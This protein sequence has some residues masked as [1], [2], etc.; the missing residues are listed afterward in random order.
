VLRSRGLPQHVDVVQKTCQAFS[1]TSLASLTV[2]VTAV[3]AVGN[4]LLA[5]AAVKTSEASMTFSDDAGGTWTTLVSNVGAVAASQMAVGICKVQADYTGKSIAITFPTADTR[6]VLWVFEL[7]GCAPISEIAA[8]H[9][10]TFLR[11]STLDTSRVYPS[12]NPTDVGDLVVAWSQVNGQ[13]TAYTAPASPQMT[14]LPATTPGF[15]AL[16]ANTSVVGSYYVAPDRTGFAPTGTGTAA[17]ASEGCTF[18]IQAARQSPRA[19]QIVG[20]AVAGAAARMNRLGRE[21]RR[22]RSGILV[23][24][25]GW[26]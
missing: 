15:I 16:A 14:N 23:P 21:W 1:T 5:L 12:A 6:R 24:E 19:Q 18:V 25:L 17:V 13:E 8:T 10:A 9:A 4:H 11:D 20:S 2:A 26:S 22:T 7:L 3:P